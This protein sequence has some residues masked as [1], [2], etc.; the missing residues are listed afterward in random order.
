MAATRE[1]AGRAAAAV[2]MADVV[3]ADAPDKEEAEKAGGEE[4]AAAGVEKLEGT[5]VE[6]RAAMSA[7]AE[8]ASDGG[9]ERRT[10]E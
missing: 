2:A 5:E 9:A 6:G 1:R 4:Q 3:V 7:A 10:Q 8:T